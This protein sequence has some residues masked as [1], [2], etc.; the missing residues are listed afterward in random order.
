[1]SLVPP[2]LSPA[3]LGIMAASCDQVPVGGVQFSIRTWVSCSQLVTLGVGNVTPVDPSRQGCNEQ[4][5]TSKS[6]DFLTVSS[7]CLQ[8]MSKL[9][10]FIIDSVPEFPLVALPGPVDTRVQMMTG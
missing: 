10:S 4:V 9:P 5:V 6:S 1:M 7:L 8:Q 3:T 2:F